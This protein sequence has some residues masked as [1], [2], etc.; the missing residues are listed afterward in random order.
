MG[1][2][3]AL[4]MEDEMGGRGCWVHR[5]VVGLGDCGWSLV[6]EIFLATYSPAHMARTQIPRRKM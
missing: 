3:M 5:V 1:A 2:V 6:G 4:T